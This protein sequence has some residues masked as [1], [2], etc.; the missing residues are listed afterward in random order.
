[1]RFESDLCLPV[2]SFD[3]PSRQDG[4]SVGSLCEPLLACHSIRF[5]RFKLQRIPYITCGFLRC[6]PPASCSAARRYIT[7]SPSS[8]QQLFGTFFR[9]VSDPVPIAHPE[10]KNALRLFRKALAGQ[11]VGRVAAALRLLCDRFRT[12][13]CF[14]HALR[15]RSRFRRCGDVLYTAS[16]SCAR[17][18]LSL[19]HEAPQRGETGAPTTDGAGRHRLV[20]LL[21]QEAETAR[22]KRRLPTWT[23]RPSTRTR[24]YI[25]SRGSSCSPSILTPPWSIMRRPSPA[26]ATRPSSWSSPGT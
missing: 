6:M 23:T 1:M 13:F 4:V 16:P 5:S 21:L 9:A 12:A 10:M 8:C 18:C 25:Y 19:I 15:S 14:Q 11:H 3:G 20:L 17:G 2:W 26:E 22:A 24:A 7:H